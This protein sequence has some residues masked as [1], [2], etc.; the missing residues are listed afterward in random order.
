M[1]NTKDFQFS[2][3]GIKVVEFMK[4]LQSEPQFDITMPMTYAYLEDI[5]HSAGFTRS[6][7]LQVINILFTAGVIDLK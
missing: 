1:Q 5:G 6:E 7:S 4:I 3:T 2:G